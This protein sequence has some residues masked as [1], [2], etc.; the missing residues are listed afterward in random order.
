M[1]T[2]V[3]SRRFHHRRLLLPATV[4]ILIA[5]AVAAM[6]VVHLVVL[7]CLW[8]NLAGTSPAGVG[9]AMKCFRPCTAWTYGTYSSEPKTNDSHGDRATMTGTL[10]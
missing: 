8:C 10:V 3:S 9:T 1:A 2:M 5:T 4:P 6:T 7:C